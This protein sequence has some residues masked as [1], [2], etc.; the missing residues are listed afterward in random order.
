MK[1]KQF[2]VIGLGRFGGSICRTLSEQGM[3]VLAIDIDEDRVNEYAS[4]ASHAVVGDSTDEAVLKS[5]G[6][7]NFDHV[8]VAIGDNIQASILTTLILK[9]L[10]VQNITVKATNDYHEKVLKKIGADQIVHP[11]RDMG[12]RIAHSIISNNVLD[13]LELSDVHSIVEIA[14]SHRLE[15]HSLL[16]LDIRARYGINIVAIKRGNEVIVSPLASEMIRKG[17]IL[18]VI[19]ADEDIDRFEAKVVSG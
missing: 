6:I 11:E 3:E 14:A 9:E 2:A 5:L 15:G 10:G 4:I 7:R 12:E 8:I 19:G 17:D 18:V 13:Y 16:E 1:K